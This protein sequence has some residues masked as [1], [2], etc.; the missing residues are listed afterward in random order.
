M[1]V[2]ELKTFSLNIVSNVNVM[3]LIYFANYLIYPRKHVMTAVADKINNELTLLLF[4]VLDIKN[5]KK[6]KKVVGK[7][8]SACNKKE[9]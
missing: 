5:G 2:I 8:V 6:V 4:L 7:S 9:S 1:S 3:P